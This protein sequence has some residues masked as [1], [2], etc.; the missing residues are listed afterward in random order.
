MIAAQRLNELPELAIF[1]ITS[2]GSFWQF[3]QPKSVNFTRNKTFYS[4]QDL[5]QLFAV[6]NWVFQQCEVQLDQLVAA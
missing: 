1:G 5:D 6:V 2:N 3:G 4:I